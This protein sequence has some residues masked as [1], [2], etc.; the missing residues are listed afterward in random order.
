MNLRHRLFLPAML[1]G[2]AL[3]AFN[4]TTLPPAAFAQAPTPT[5]PPAADPRIDPTNPLGLAFGPGPTISNSGAFPDLTGVV[6]LSGDGAFRA[7]PA[8]AAILPASYANYE[9]QN[10]TTTI[11]ADGRFSTRFDYGDRVSKV[12]KVGSYTKTGDFLYRAPDNSPVTEARHTTVAGLPALTLFPTENVVNREAAP[13]QLWFTKDGIIYVI[14][15]S[16]FRESADAL[17][18]AADVANNLRSVPGAPA[19]GT[20]LAIAEHARRGLSW[21][22]IGLILVFF[23]IHTVSRMP[24]NP[25]RK[26]R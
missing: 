17:A 7:R 23:G 21:L 20:G 19:T 8:S 11:S 12:I 18:I 15:F 2:I 26:L 16:G 14:E 25:H 24:R 6:S 10:A 9:L 4:L 5:A 3:V 13:R 1:A 22:T